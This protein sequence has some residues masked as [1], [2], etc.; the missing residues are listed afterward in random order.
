VSILKSYAQEIENQNFN[1]VSANINSDAFTGFEFG[2]NH[3]AT[4]STKNVFF[5]AKLNIPLMLSVKQKKIDTW[6]LKFGAASEI[7]EFNKFLLITDFNLFTIRHKQDLGTFLPIG[8]NLRLTPSLKTKNGYW[9]F[10]IKYNQTIT[11]YIKHSDIVKERFNDLT[12]KNGQPLN[13]EPENGFYS[14]TGNSINYGIET[15][16][17]LSEKMNIYFDIGI[18]QFLSKYT[19]GF[20]AMM[21][22]QVPF[23][24]DLQLNH[25]I[26]NR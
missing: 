21:F 8:F 12:D 5:Y 9:G 1:F 19:K 10:Q 14:F 3:F 16:F 20:D 11:T 15:K 24:M 17:N 13:L 6:E 25:K 7:Y 22:G 2:Y 18:T 26:K 23:Y 4:I